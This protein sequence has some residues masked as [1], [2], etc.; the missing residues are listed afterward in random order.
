LGSSLAVRL[1]ETNLLALSV[2][3]TVSVGRNKNNKQQ[4]T[5]DGQTTPP[6][7][8]KI[9]VQQANKLGDA[10]PRLFEWK[11]LVMSQKNKGRNGTVP[12]QGNRGRQ[13]QA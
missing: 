12:S 13:Q 6:P 3:L 10:S 11:W 9:G 1:Q 4:Q 7:P 8:Q 5:F 2:L